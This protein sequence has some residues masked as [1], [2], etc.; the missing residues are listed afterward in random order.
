VFV[1]CG[2]GCCEWQGAREQESERN[3]RG[4]ASEHEARLKHRER[5]ERGWKRE[6]RRR[7]EGGEERREERERE[8]EES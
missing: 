5:R 6:K 3:W 1:K 7:Q 2:G 4:R 8:R